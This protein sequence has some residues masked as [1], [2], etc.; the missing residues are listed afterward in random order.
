MLFR[1]RTV[2]FFVFLLVSASPFKAA[3]ARPAHWVGT[4]AAAPVAANNTD[5]KYGVSDTTFRET[6]MF[7]WAARAFERFSV[8]NSVQT[9]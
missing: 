2:Q 5:A 4:W 1:I 8:M 3:A 7:H 6:S 9:L